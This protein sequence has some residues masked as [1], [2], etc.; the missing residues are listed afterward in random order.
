[1]TTTRQAADAVTPI[2]CRGF[3]SEGDTELPPLVGGPASPSLSYKVMPCRSR[4]LRLS[5]FLQVNSAF[6]RERSESKDPV[7]A[8]HAALIDAAEGQPVFKIMGEE[9]VDRHAAR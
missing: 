5:C 2:A 3:A 4:L 9:P 7:V 1:M 8:T 6:M